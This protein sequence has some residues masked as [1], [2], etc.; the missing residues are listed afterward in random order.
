MKPILDWMK[1]KAEAYTPGAAPSQFSP[2][3]LEYQRLPN[4]G[5]ESSVAGASPS[6]PSVP[7][8][9]DAPV[10]PRKNSAR[11][12]ALKRLF[13]SKRSRDD[14]G[15]GASLTAECE[16][17]SIDRECPRREKDDCNRYG[18]ADQ[19][20]CHRLV[21]SQPALPRAGPGFDFARSTPLGYPEGLQC[22]EVPPTDF[23][24]DVFQAAV[25]QVLQ[26]STVI[27]AFAAK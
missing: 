11:A 16:S 19:E 12:V 9:R 8:G 23:E 14:A 15:L 22:I 17:W 24:A 3:E 6:V 27:M 7:R 10:R 21:S 18:V 5:S 26:F 1:S 25:A 13:H 4:L 20:R 2:F